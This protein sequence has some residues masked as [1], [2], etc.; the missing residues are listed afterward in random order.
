MVCQGALEAQLKQ[1]FEGGQGLGDVHVLDD[2][3]LVLWRRLLLLY[4]FFL[5][6]DPAQ[7]QETTVILYM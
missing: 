4:H 5:D 6:H 3:V 1:L 7:R 2:Q